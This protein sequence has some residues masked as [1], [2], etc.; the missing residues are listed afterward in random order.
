[1]FVGPASLR[2]GRIGRW[3]PTTAAAVD[4]WP[5]TPPGWARRSSRRSGPRPWWSRHGAPSSCQEPGA[6]HGFKHGGCGWKIQWDLEEIAG[7]FGEDHWWMGWWNIFKSMFL[8]MIYRNS[9]EFSKPGVWKNSRPPIM[10]RPT[11][12]LP[13]SFS[14]S[15]GISKMVMEC[16]QKRLLKN[17][18]FFVSG[19]AAKKS[20]LRCL[21]KWLNPLKLETSSQVKFQSS[22]SDG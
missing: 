5:S 2:R 12:K 11:E 19:N 7:G 20:W 13:T 15:T 17:P 3:P 21:D 14:H 8:Q 4:P 1:M 10:G 6:R 16:L 22:T 18:S 9:Q